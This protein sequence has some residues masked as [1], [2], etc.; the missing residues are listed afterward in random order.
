MG[1]AQNDAQHE[2]CMYVCCYPQGKHVRS[3][4]VDRQSIFLWRSRFSRRTSEPILAST[5]PVGGARGT[6]WV[7]AGSSRITRVVRD[8]WPLPACRIR[9]RPCHPMVLV[10][11]WGAPSTVW[12]TPQQH[13]GNNVGQ[14][15]VC[16]GQR[17]FVGSRKP[18]AEIAQCCTGGW[19]KHAHRDARR[20]GIVRRRGMQGP[21]GPRSKTVCMRMGRKTC[22]P[23]LGCT[24]SP[25]A[26]S[27]T[28]WWR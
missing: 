14:Q 26:L 5:S 1:R 15:R 10:K 6:K 28:S 19:D 11:G 16:S 8:S 24:W 9:P 7:G 27:F 25:P 17:E 13:A 22:L 18:A 3:P 12:A 21:W 20:Y 23:T 2:D 4:V